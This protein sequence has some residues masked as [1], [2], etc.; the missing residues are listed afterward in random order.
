MNNYKFSGNRVSA[1]KMRLLREKGHEGVN[2]L[3]VNKRET[4]ITNRMH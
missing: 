2:K 1:K 4:K 3:E